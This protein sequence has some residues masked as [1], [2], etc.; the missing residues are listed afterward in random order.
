[1]KY[2]IL[3]SSAAGVNGAKEIRKLDPNGE[4]LLISKDKTIYSRCILH[5]Y[6]S[7]DRKMDRLSFVEK[8]FLQRYKIKFMG[9]IEAISLNV[10]KKEVHLSNREITTYDKLLISTGSNSFFPPIENMDNAKNVIGFR[11][12]DDCIE[13]M[14]LTKKIDNIVVM[15]GGLVG[16]DSI[17]GL[18]NYKKNLFLVEMQNRLLSIQL[19]KKASSTY[20]SAFEEKGV[21]FYFNLGA[22]RINLDAEDR[23]KS[24]TLSNGEEIPCEL[25]IVT[26]GVRAN[27]SFLKDS[28]IEVDRRGLIIDAS[29]KTNDP[30]I[31]G[32]GDVTGRGPIWP[33]AVKEGII[34]ASNMVGVHK[35]VTDFFVSKSAMNFFG[36]TTMSLG[37][38]EPEDNS[39]IVEIEEDKKGNYKKIIHKDGKIHGAVLQGDLS[40]AG[41]LTQLIKENIDVSKVK[42]SLFKIDYSDFFHVTDNFEFSYEKGDI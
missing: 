24:I 30:D 27:V 33:V 2:V 6:I 25:L 14:E 15:G 23:V 9:G 16:V 18:L 42:K 36:I 29:G 39:Y 22:Q 5:H 32:A 7:G 4:I 37:I 38:N 41:T 12:I 34:A 8:D 21:K 40:Y 19:D 20:E 26:A 10:E 35:E 11:N 31:Y 13:I 1:M 17:T 28:G 3:G